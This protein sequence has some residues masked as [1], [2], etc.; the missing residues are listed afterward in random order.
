[1]TI[2]APVPSSAAAFRAGAGARLSTTM[3]F[4]MTMTRMRGGTG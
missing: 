3:M 4:T 1:M 2:D